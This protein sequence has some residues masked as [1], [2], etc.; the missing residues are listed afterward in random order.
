[1]KDD[2]ME[3]EKRRSCERFSRP[4]A[5]RGRR[6]NFGKKRKSKV[7]VK[8]HR[9]D[10]YYY[11]DYD[12]SVTNN[13]TECKN[14]EDDFV[15]PCDEPNVEQNETKSDLVSNFLQLHTSERERSPSPVNTPATPALDL[16]KL[17]EQIDFTEP[18]SLF[19]L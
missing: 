19:T 8:A 3:H 6:T 16:S 1:M 13:N 9:E 15:K 10:I 11:K 17:H 5:P 2:D 18:V 4:L 7:F 14:F 12:L